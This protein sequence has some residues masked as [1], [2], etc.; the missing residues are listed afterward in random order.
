M[1]KIFCYIQ[2]LLL[3]TCMF[4]CT[5]DYSNIPME[6]P[7]TKWVCADPDI[8]FEVDKDQ[9]TLGEVKVNGNIIKMEVGFRNPHNLYFLSGDNTPSSPLETLF[10]GT[11]TFSKDKMIVKINDDNLFNNKYKKLIFIREV[12]K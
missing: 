11:G 6:R 5:P 4:G 8:W 10:G 3:L 2:V 7:N 12:K 1:K 9:Q